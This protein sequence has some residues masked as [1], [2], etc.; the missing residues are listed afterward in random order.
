MTLSLISCHFQD[1]F[2][3]NCRRRIFSVFCANPEA[4]RSS[5]A[6]AR[7]DLI[8]AVAL[9]LTFGSQS[10][11]GLRNKHP[12]FIRDHELPIPRTSRRFGGSCGADSPSTASPS[13]ILPKESGCPSSCHIHSTVGNRITQVDSKPSSERFSRSGQAGADLEQALSLADFLHGDAVEEIARGPIR[14]LS[15]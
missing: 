5:P 8:G 2:L 6:K 9:S 12:V 13:A 7:S 10:T 4:G 15:Q 3:H 1:D 14:R 11:T